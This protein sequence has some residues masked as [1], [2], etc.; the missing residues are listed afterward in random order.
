MKKKNIISGILSIIIGLT[1]T[2]LVMSGI[3]QGEFMSNLWYGIHGILAIVA[4]YVVG[5][6]CITT[7]DRTDMSYSL[8][9][10]LTCIIGTVVAISFIV[11]GISQIFFDESVHQA[12]LTMLCFIIVVGLVLIVDI[13]RS[14]IYYRSTP[15]ELMDDPMRRSFTD[16]QGN[17]RVSFSSLSENQEKSCKSKKVRRNP[18]CGI[19]EPIPPAQG[20]PAFRMRKK[21][22]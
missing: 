10:N 15:R 5:F 8:S 18:R 22:A 4:N 14:A 16:T 1:I 17:R 7:R 9:H 11:Y 20:D 3:R 19:Y 2:H 6:A 12:Y 13:I 21:E